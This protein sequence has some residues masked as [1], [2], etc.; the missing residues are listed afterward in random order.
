MNTKIRQG[1]LGGLAA[2]LAMTAFMMIVPILGM[3]KMSLPEVLA[4]M[5]GRPVV[6]GWI[7]HFGSGMMFAFAYAFLFIYWVKVVANAMLKGII[8]GVT[9]FILV[10]ITMAIL[11]VVV[12]EPG[13]SMIST[14]IVSFVGHV[15]FGIVVSLLI[16]DGVSQERR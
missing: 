4:S 9:V 16:S 11:G 13:E 10:Q 14:M 7:V 15:I 2:T 5:M 8:F 12:V 3:P 6:V 1:F